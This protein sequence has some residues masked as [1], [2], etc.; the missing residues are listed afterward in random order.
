MS[1]FQGRRREDWPEGGPFHDGPYEIGDY[2]KVL[3]DDGLPK[4][5]VHHDGKLT[6]ECWRAVLP[7]GG[8]L[9][10]ANLD[11]HTVREHDDG[12]ISVRPNDGSSNSILVSR[13]GAKPASWHGYIE[14]G[15]FRAE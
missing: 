4:M 9:G 11:L 12:T 5:I 10:I 15:V 14:H 1:E 13:N 6:E 7:L 3:A 2:W 8:G